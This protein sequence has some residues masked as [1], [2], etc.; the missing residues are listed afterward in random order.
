MVEC[1]FYA[2]DA[3]IRQNARK[4]NTVLTIL[5]VSMLPVVPVSH[6]SSKHKSICF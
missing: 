1:G 2:I 3:V 6:A 4:E 5:S